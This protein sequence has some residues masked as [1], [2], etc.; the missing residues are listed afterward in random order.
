MFIYNP[1]DQRRLDIVKILVD[2][3][4]VYVTSNNQPINSCQIDPQW[5]GRKSNLMEKKIFEVC[6][7]IIDRQELHSFSPSST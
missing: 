3:Y 6:E 1:T 4:Q 2:T 7:Q 5:T